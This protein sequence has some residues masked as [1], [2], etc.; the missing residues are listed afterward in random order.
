MKLKKLLFGSCAVFAAALLTGCISFHDYGSTP[1]DAMTDNENMPYVAQAQKAYEQ[2]MQFSKPVEIKPSGKAQLFITGNISPEYPPQ[3]KRE[4]LVLFENALMGEVGKLRDFRIVGSEARNMSPGATI[5]NVDD[6][7]EQQNRPYLLSFHILRVYFT[8]V[9]QGLLRTADLISDIS[10]GGRDYR[11]STRTLRENHLWAAYAQV[12]VALTSPAGQRIFTFNEDVTTLDPFLAPY[13][14][15]NKLKDAVAYAAQKAMR[16]YALQFGPPMY[17]KQS[18]GGG[19]FVQISAGSEYGIQKGQ[20][21]EFYR[22]AVRTLPALP[23]EQPRTEAFRTPVAYGTV[24]AWDAPVE[25][26]FAWVYVPGNEKPETHRVF[27]WTSARVV[28]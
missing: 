10:G 19:L 14:D 16:S 13:P 21:I 15:P 20:K 8:N 4:L 26:N 24:G 2:R 28:E 25:R 5:T 1:A 23:G 6:E 11:R 9:S 27:T 17:V 22:H 12:E 3:F 7:A 18:I